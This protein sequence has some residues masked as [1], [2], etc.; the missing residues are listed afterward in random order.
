[1]AQDPVVD[2]RLVELEVK[3]SYAEDLID[4]LNDTVYRQQQQID[5]LVREVRALRGQVE[6]LQPGEPRSPADEVPPHY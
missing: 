5:A 3:V 4:A 2:T 1:V 6:A